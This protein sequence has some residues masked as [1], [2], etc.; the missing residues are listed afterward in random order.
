MRKIPSLNTVTGS[1]LMRVG[2][3]KP[4]PNDFCRYCRV[5]RFELDENSA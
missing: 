5:W 2:L 4:E 1:T 3:R